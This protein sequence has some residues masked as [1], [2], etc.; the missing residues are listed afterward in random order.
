MV[1]FNE[2]LYDLQGAGF[3]DVFLPFLLIFVVLFAILEKTKLFGTEG[4]SKKPRKN[5]NV[6]FAFITAMIVIVNTEVIATMNL[7][8]SKISLI[9]IIFVMFLIIFGLWAGAQYEPAGWL[10]FV[11][12]VVAILGTIWALT[13]E[14]GLDLPYWA[15][16]T[17]WDGPLV[18]GAIIGILTLWF[19][20]GSGE[21]KPK[22]GGWFE[23][24]QKPK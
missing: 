23:I 1:D 15:Y 8:L 11:G 12:M 20:L 5:I 13:P 2:L 24:R 22:N 6:V 14:I 19:L 7:Y 21:S 16:P 18:L 9:I 4:E 3:F 17:D 10:F